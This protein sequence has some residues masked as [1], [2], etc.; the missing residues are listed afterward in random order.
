ME[1]YYEPEN[2]LSPHESGKTDL[3]LLKDRA[4]DIAAEGIT[5][6]DMRLP[7]QPLIYINEGFERLT[8]YSAKSMLGKNCRF[9]QGEDSDP[10]TVEEIRRALASGTE[11]TVEI[12]NHTKN[13]EPFWNRLSLTPVT[14]S[15]G[16]VTHF[17]G[18]QSDIT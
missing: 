16:G 4:L 13:G 7:D 12:L 10:G 18:V 2:P 5:I 17:I 11:C 3:L 6:A 15:K 8:G 14:D 1:K 9:L